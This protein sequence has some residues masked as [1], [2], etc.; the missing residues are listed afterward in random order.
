MRELR[1][2][3]NTPVNFGLS[4]LTPLLYGFLF[5]TSLAGS[6]QTVSSGG[7]SVPYLTFVTPGIGVLGLLMF[8]N[9]SGA[10]IWQERVSGMLR[11][12]AS[13]PI[14]PLE[15][16]L[17][18]LLANSGMAM[19]QGSV[20]MVMF[21]VSMS[22]TVPLTRLLLGLLALLVG[23]IL[24]VSLYTALWTLVP[25][26]QTGSLLAN[27]ATMV[28]LFTS[29]VFYT[30]ESMPPALRSVALYNPLAYITTVLRSVLLGQ[31]V[32]LRYPLVLV[33]FV[34]LLTAISTYS[35]NR[36]MSTE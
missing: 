5:A 24:I 12:I 11:E 28:L 8:A 31:A 16:A 25:S 4:A 35:C 2:F 33:G 18:K 32:P 27:L 1:L 30:I 13:C 14:G 21:S 10:G 23:G 36:L 34:V 6:V 20:V 22:N 19:V 3:L 9:M 26:A 7:F 29:P 17:G 15:Y